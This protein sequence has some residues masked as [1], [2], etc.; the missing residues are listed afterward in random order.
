[1]RWSKY[2]TPGKRVILK[3][4]FLPIC[5]QGEYRW[6]EFV[7][8]EKNYWPVS[9]TGNQIV[10]KRFVDEW[11]FKMENIKELKQEAYRIATAD[12]TV[13][14]GKMYCAEDRVEAMK[15]YAML[16]IVEKLTTQ[17]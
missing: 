14:A 13:C 15:A 17:N 10:I 8:I 5:L 12:S 1:M 3:F 2:K 9:V 16:T 4:A 7:K 6:L 11:R